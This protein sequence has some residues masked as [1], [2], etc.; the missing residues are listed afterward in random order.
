MPWACCIFVLSLYLYFTKTHCFG[1]STLVEL[2]NDG[3]S[4]G[5]AVPDVSKDSNIFIF[6]IIEFRD[7]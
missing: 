2:K 4:I 1:L 5:Q 7:L 6:K 3:A